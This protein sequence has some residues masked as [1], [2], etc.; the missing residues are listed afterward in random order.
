MYYKFLDSEDVN[1]AG[2]IGDALELATEL[3]IR[4]AMTATEGSPISHC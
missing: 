1:K 2:G 4:T 3:T